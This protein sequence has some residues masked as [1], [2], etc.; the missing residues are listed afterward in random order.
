MVAAPG[1]GKGTQGELLASQFGEQ[2]VS[3]GEVLRAE[4]LPGTP[5]GRE[6]NLHEREMLLNTLA[7]FFAF[8]GSAIGAGKHL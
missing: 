5:A 1:G 7:A 4:A 6:A 2:H 3:S 8:Q